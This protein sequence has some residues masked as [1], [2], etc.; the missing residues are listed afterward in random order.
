MRQIQLTRGKVATVDDA[1]YNWLN[2]YKWFAAQYHHTCYAARSFHNRVQYMHRL[3]LGFQFGDKRITDHIDGNGLNNRR[4]N[5][6]VCTKAQNHQSSRKQ[7]GGTSKYKGVHWHCDIRKWHS[8]IQINKKQIHLG[9]FYSEIAAA[10]AYDVAA[11]EYHGGFAL[12]NETLGLGGGR[13][14]EIEIGQIR[15]LAQ[16]LKEVR[17]E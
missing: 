2:K 4:V 10:Q 12:T 17:D 14:S 6:R 3:I 5:L 16:A 1:D 9:Y 13:L 8:Q 7:K 15:R 11:L